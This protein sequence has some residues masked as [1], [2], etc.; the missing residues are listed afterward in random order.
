MKTPA[1]VLVTGF[2]FSPDNCFACQ[3][4]CVVDQPGPLLIH[5]V[6]RVRYGLLEPLALFPGSKGGA[7]E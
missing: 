1:K 6:W 2:L 5:L 7:W 3:E 4:H